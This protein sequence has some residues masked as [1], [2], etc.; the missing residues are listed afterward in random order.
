V[1]KDVTGAGRFDH[2]K[3]AFPLAGA[4]K[5]ATCE[6]CHAGGVFKGVAFSSCASCHKDPHGGRLGAGC[7]ACHDE[8]AWRTKKLDH[9]RTAF[10]LRGRHATVDC[11]KCH[12]KPAALVKPVSSSCAVC[13]TDPHKGTFKEDCAAC[14]SESTFKKGTFDHATTRFPLLDRHAAVECVS[15][16]KTRRPAANDFKGLS[17]SCESCHADVHRGELGLSCEKC[18]SARAWEVK[19]FSHAKPRTFFEGQHASVAC[20]GCHSTPVQ[21]ARAGAAAPLLRVGFTATVAACVSCHRDVHLGQ[22]KGGCESCHDVET[23]KFAI[24]RF[25]HDRTRLPL[26]GAHAA[27]QCDRCHRVETAAF[28]SGA[29]TALR[30]TGV[31]TDCAGCHQDPHRGQLNRECQVCHLS[32]TFKLPRYTHQ[33]ARSLRAFFSGRHAAAACS[34]CHKPLATGAANAALVAA[35]Y[36]VST[37]CTDCHTDI[38]RG[39]LGSVCEACH[40]P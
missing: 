2:S 7:A 4:H 29:G 26:T 9:T 8:T 20:A 19:V 17:T 34:A 14:H 21:P 12:L 36:T 22:L 25:P 40:K 23:P 6:R 37:A 27:L 3:S 5:A 35:N 16:H 32:D 39:A 15:C 33:N 10:P 24:A 38:H 18:H 1:F 30:L 31:A 13:H 28:P 11:A